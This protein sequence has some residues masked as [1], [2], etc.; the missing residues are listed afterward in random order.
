M[1]LLKVRLEGRGACASG[2]VAKGSASAG[3]EVIVV[4]RDSAL[5][6]LHTPENKGNTAKQKSTT[7]TADNTTN[8][9]LVA[10][11]QTAAVAAGTAL[12]LGWVGHGCL[13]G[14]SNVG[15]RAC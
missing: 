3:H 12:G 5:T 8:D 1:I 10:L 15:A 13:T 6:L 2:L 11:A 14:G 7:N 9:L 4:F